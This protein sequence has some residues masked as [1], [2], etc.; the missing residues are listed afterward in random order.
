MST[1]SP[2]VA[3][4]PQGDTATLLLTDLVRFSSS[5]ESMTIGRVRLPDKPLPGQ[6]TPPCP[7]GYVGING[8]CW[9]KLDARVPNC[10]KGSA[11]YKDGCYLPIKG[12]KPV[13][14]SIDQRIRGRR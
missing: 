8:G 9:A 1:P 5:K 4:L 10:P 2:L 3:R 6:D 12:D 14:M 13:P 7:E 11:E